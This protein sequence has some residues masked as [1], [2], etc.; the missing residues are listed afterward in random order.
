MRH[1]PAPAPRAACGRRRWIGT[2]PTPTRRIIMNRTRPPPRLGR[3]GQPRRQRGRTTTVAR[4][5]AAAASI[6]AVDQNLNAGNGTGKRRRG[7]WTIAGPA[8]SGTWWRMINWRLDGGD[9]AQ[10]RARLEVDL[11]V[12]ERR[13]E[14]LALG[15]T[16]LI[17]LIDS[18]TATS[19]PD[20]AAQARRP[21]SMPRRT[22]PASRSARIACG[23][24]SSRWRDSGAGRCTHL[25]RI[26]TSSRDTARPRR[27]SPGDDPIRRTARI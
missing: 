6:E 16:T 11:V 2:S 7:P 26:M 1:A 9:R 27:R 25:V 14:D 23:R 18:S 15:R 20:R 21:V 19:A 8:A 13:R 4:T 5:G 24:P 3:P 22:R 17:A 12:E 10:W